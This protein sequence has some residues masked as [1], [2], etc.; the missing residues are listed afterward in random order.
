MATLQM[1]SLIKG[2]RGSIGSLVLRQVGKKTIVSGAPSLPVR[3]S[4]KQKENRLKF[5]HASAWA[6][7]MMKDPQKKAYYLQKAK[8][9]KLTN[10]YTAAITDYMRKGEVREIDHSRYN[11]KVGDTVKIKV[12]KKGFP[13]NK[14]NIILMDANGEPI[15]SGLATR[16]DAGEFVYKFT[17]LPENQTA[18]R[19]KVVL[20]DHSFNEVAKEQTI[21]VL[22]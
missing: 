21:T 2:V 19:I 12:Y 16:K 22:S 6:K 3:Q 9:L 17:T 13:V 8:K 14:V 11:G 15:G 1:N 20:S 7:A 4:E 5:K 10:A 18:L